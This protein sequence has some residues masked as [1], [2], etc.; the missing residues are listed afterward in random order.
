MEF[1]Q[2]ILI[3]TIIAA[4]VQIVTWVHRAEYAAAVFGAA[5]V[6]VYLCDILN[7]SFSGVTYIA[8]SIG[9]RSASSEA[10][11]V[12]IF[13]LVTT[14]ILYS[15][16]VEIISARW[17][18]QR[19][20]S[21]VLIDRNFSLFG[22]LALS[23]TFGGAVLSKILSVGI[24]Q[25]LELR[26]SV[27][28]DNF[29]ILLGYFVLPVLV[30]LGLTRAVQIRGARALIM[31]ISLAGLLGV[32][33]LTGSRSG[34]FLGAVIPV[35]ALYWKKI[36]ASARSVKRDLQRVFL[37]AALIAVPVLGGG[38]YLANTRGL[39]ES[40][41]FLNGT[42]VSQ[43]DV[44]VDLIASDA[45]GVAGGSTYLASITSAVPRSLWAEKPLPGNVVSSMVLTP[46]RYFLTGAETTAGLLG[47]AFINVGWM[48]P[49]IAA[50]LMIIFLLLCSRFLASRDDILWM[51]GIILLIRG[52]NLLRG[53]MTNVV[54]PSMTA[55]IVWYVLYKKAKPGIAPRVPVGA[56]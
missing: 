44:F 30:S 1:L 54:V 51:V 56:R 25:T 15:F 17:K 29:L 48:A 47:E 31:W 12:A 13:F 55:I 42:D 24:A 27:F 20:D 22:F 35:L 49:M 16:G 26:Q 10:I 33:A 19:I 2:L 52:L 41:S 39:V 5:Y 8:A 50:G 40:A 21:L 18:S 45:G 11:S 53:D 36:A 23:G 3:L 32:T 46:D 9:A 43:A 14:W 34:L 37:V 6:V 4:L 7:I 38:V 28:S